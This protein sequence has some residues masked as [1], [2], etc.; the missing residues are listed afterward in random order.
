MTRYL[1]RTIVVAIA[2]AMATTLAFA[3]TIAASTDKDTNIKE[4]R[5]YEKI[6]AHGGGTVEGFDTSS[7][8]DAVMNAI[9]SGFKLIELD[10]EFSYDEEIIMLHD[11]DRTITNYLGRKYD[12]K[13]TLKQ[14]NNQL[15]CGRFEPL[16]FDKLIKI[17][18]E[19]PQIRIVTDTKGDN[20]KL[21][22]TIAEKYPN[23]INR[24]IP[25]I[26]DYKEFGPVAD[27]GYKDIIFTL[28]MQDTIDY[29]RLLKF[30]KKNDIY[31][32]TVGKDYWIKDLPVKL[33]ADDVIV[34]THPIY[35]VEEAEEQFDK[36]AYGIYSSTLIPSE[37]EGYG[38]EFY[39]MQTNENGEKVKLSDANLGANAVRSIKIHGNLDYKALKYK[40]DGKLYEERIKEIDNPYE[41][42]KLAI[43]IWD[44]SSKVRKEPVYVMEYLVVKNNKEIRVLDEKYEYRLKKIKELPQFEETILSE[45][46]K[47]SENITEILSKSFIAKAGKYYYYN[48]GIVGKYYV[49]Q[50][51]MMAQ[52]YFDGSTILPLAETLKSLGASS[53][54]MDSAKYV[55]IYMDGQSTISQVYSCFIRRS[56]YNSRIPVPIS[57]YRG[58]TMAGGNVI[59]VASGRDFI[60]EDGLIIILPKDCKIEKKVEKDLIEFANLLYKD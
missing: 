5:T 38:A 43:E 45:K 59:S 58:K 14:F 44:I 30:V 13:L 2:F 22:T 31:A 20:I 1:I 12:K 48:Q 60:E 46:K 32:V 35:T 15:I 29:N 10:M 51:L 18:D 41:I 4:E 6:I 3:E 25:Q 8:V 34:Y 27:L 37:I 47:T 54:S 56:T 26:Y 19:N 42:H 57:L 24:M 16:T 9:S 39:L 11:W 50:E 53:I 36:G 28:Y 21:L 23:Y 55:Y 7:S 33:S 52:K 40:L 17:L 49:G